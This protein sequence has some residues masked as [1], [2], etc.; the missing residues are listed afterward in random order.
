LNTV[1]QSL[2]HIGRGGAKD[3]SQYQGVLVYGCAYQLLGSLQGV[4]WG[5]V[6]VHV[7]SDDGLGTIWKDVQ[8]ALPEGGSQW[9][10]G[11]EKN[12]CA[13]VCL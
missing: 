7:D 3:V 8:G 13:H 6:G 5:C 1:Y 11:N 10:M 2:G 12:A 4:F 9:C